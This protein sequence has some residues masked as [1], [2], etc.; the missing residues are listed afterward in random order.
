MESEDE[1][2]VAMIEDSNDEE[3]F[4]GVS[5]GEDDDDD[6]DMDDVI[7]DYDGFMDHESDDSDDLS[8]SLNHH[9]VR[10]RVIFFFH[11]FIA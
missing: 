10:S 1:M 3:E 5:G 2:P 11:L 7:M 6:S 4:Y 9:H 8:Y